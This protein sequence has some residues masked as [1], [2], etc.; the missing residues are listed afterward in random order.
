M[1]CNE[2]KPKVAAGNT[3]TRKKS[4]R[5]KANGESIRSNIGNDFETRR[6]NNE[7]IK[8]EEI[9]EVNVIS[10]DSPNYFFSSRK[11]EEVLEGIGYASSENSEYDSPSRDVE[12]YESISLSSK[13]I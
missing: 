8:D 7:E 10:K 2:S 3:V 1:G 5:S 13:N 12:P 4:S 6:D 9:K 11:N